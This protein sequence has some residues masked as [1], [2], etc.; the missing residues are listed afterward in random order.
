MTRDGGV[1]NSPGSLTVDLFMPGMTALHRV[2]LAGLAMTLEALARDDTARDLRSLGVWEVGERAVTL[3]WH[4]DGTIFFTALLGHS[5]RLTD[6][7]LIWFPALGHPLDQA[8]PGQAIV[9]HEALLGTF[10]QHGRTRGGTA[11]KQAS[12]TV[13]VDGEPRPLSF[14]PVSW[15][16]HQRA[17]FDPLRPLKVAGWLYP[18]G[19]VRH[20]RATA[21]TTLSEE[22]ARALALLYAPVG[23]IYFQIHRRAPGVRPANCLVVPDIGNLQAYA[24][25]R[26][27]FLRQGIARLQVAGVAEAAARVLAELEA[28][29]LLGRV[30][31]TRCSVIAFGAAPWAKQQQTRTALFAVVAP[32]PE[33]LRAYRAAASVFRV[34]LAASRPDPQ[35]GEARWW[36]RVP[37][38]PDLV[39][40]NVIAGAPWWRG[41]TALWERGR[42]ATKPEQRGWALQDERE[43]L[44]VMVGDARTMPDGP[45]A[46]LVRACQAAWRRRLGELGERARDQGVDFSSLAEREY[47]RVR[48]SFT[49]C[50]NAAMLRQTLTDYW[51]RAGTLPDLQEAWPE[52]LP[53]LNERWRD[54]RDLALLALAS[55]TP[56][57][58]GDASASTVGGD[59][60]EE[61]RGGGV[62]R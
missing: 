27:S 53:F 59:A 23:A 29:G 34:T 54:A 42:Q 52:I 24:D 9:L 49:R 51:A 62:G 5:F 6:D 25:G 3:T 14:R 17:K 48:I 32:R 31:A 33:R 35:T 43:G 22:P 47:E 57:E 18:G 38:T 41:F 40:Q 21:E 19:A 1:G 7:G 56:R 55:Y 20:V 45:E 8:D 12:L 58:A 30:G 46:R 10:L 2:G 26:R 39:A 61:A 13:E 28:H 16:A 60:A 44:Q 11:T 15:Y 4:G 36:W 50:K 37:Q